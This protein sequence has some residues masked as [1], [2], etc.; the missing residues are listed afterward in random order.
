MY[1][2][3]KASQSRLVS[4]LCRLIGEIFA[5][6]P[7]YRKPKSKDPYVHMVGGSVNRV[8]KVHL[9]REEAEV[10]LLTSA[11]PHEDEFDPTDS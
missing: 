1:D 2:I 5:P 3:C 10:R 11:N 4:S 9:V 6:L 7:T 8:S